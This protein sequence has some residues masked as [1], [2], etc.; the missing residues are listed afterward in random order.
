MN[1]LTSTDLYDFICSLFYFEE[2]LP[3]LVFLEEVVVGKESFL[4]LLQEKDALVERY[5]LYCFKVFSV[6]NTFLVPDLNLAEVL[7]ITRGGTFFLQ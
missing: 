2:H 7:G 4:W 5:T 1:S 6:F 3:E